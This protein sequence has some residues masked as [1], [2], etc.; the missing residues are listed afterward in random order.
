MKWVNDQCRVVTTWSHFQV[1]LSNHL[2]CFKVRPFYFAEQLAT[3]LN[4]FKNFVKM[5]KIKL[6]KKQ[7]PCLSIDI[8]MV[9][10][11][12]SSNIMFHL[13]LGITTIFSALLPICPSVTHSQ[14]PQNSNNFRRLVHDVP[15]TIIS[16]RDW[17]EYRVPELRPFDVCEP[18]R[19]KQNFGVA[20][21]RWNLLLPFADFDRDA[22]AEII[23]FAVWQNEE[24]V[25]DADGGM[26]YECRHFIHRWN[27]LSN[28]SQSIF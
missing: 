6:T 17:N 8:E 13:D 3:A 19:N 27:R 16:S 4:T 26:Q 23:T 1:N 25:A 18:L 2:S 9:T 5:V 11:P 28:G 7:F 20:Q 10:P 21:S 24:F 14:A 22:N 15:V 12:I